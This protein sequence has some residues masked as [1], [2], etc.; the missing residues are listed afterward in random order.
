[1]AKRNLQVNTKVIASVTDSAEK[2]LRGT[3]QPRVLC[4]APAWN[5][6]ERIARVVQAVPGEFV[7][8]TVV[9]DDGSGDDTAFHAENSGAIVI[10]SGANRGVGAAIRSGIDY[11]I[12]N[13]YDIV[14]VAC[15]RSSRRPGSTWSR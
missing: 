14:A 1:M 8:T 12:A 15:G 3:C 13:G 11:A 5:E 6:G 2:L 10:R 7:E 4:V 9:V